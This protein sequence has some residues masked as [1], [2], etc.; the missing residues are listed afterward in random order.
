[1]E[2]KVNRVLEHISRGKAFD[3][4]FTAF[5]MVFTPEEIICYLW[6]GRQ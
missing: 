3:T 6:E 2:G 1:M 5:Q 4:V